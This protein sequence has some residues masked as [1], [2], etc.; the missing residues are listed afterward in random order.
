M[1]F[2]FAAGGIVCTFIFVDYVYLG[3][4]LTSFYILIYN[5]NIY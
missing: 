2:G 1:G 5:L 4:L 3:S